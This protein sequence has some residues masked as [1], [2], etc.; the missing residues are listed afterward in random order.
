MHRLPEVLQPRQA[1]PRLLPLLPLLLV[2]VCL[3]AFFPLSQTASRLTRE[4]ANVA[5]RCGSDTQL[6]L[7]QRR[8]GQVSRDVTS[9][10][11]SDVAAAA[12]DVEAGGASS[13][14]FS[15]FGETAI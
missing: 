10:E 3:F 1:Q 9:P 2:F 12:R 6:H 5:S 7:L 15:G 11:L 4:P 8:R 13:V 14:A